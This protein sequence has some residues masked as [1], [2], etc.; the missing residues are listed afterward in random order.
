MDNGTRKKTRKS[1]AGNL[2]RP[3]LSGLMLPDEWTTPVARRS[4]KR[5]VRANELLR[6]IRDYGPLSRAEAARMLGFNTRTVSLCLESLQRDGLIVKQKE[7]TRN[8]RGRRPVPWAFNPHAACVLG[9]DVGRSVITSTVMDLAG[10]VLVSK[11]FP[12]DYPKAP[13]QQVRWLNG[14]ASRML[15]EPAVKALPLAGIGLCP[16]GIFHARNAGTR[17]REE[18]DWLGASLCSLT[19]APVFVEDDSRLV[20]LGERWFGNISDRVP[21]I[22]T[23]NVTDGLGVAVI[24]GDSLYTGL[25]HAAGELGHVPLGE[26]GVPCYCGAQSCLENTASGHGIERMAAQARLARNGK[27]C[28]AVDVMEMAPANETARGIVARFAEGL[29]L[30]TTVVLSLLNPGVLV[31]SGRLARF[32][33]LY[34]ET[35]RRELARVAPPFIVS[36]TP[37]IVSELH[38]NAVTYGTC[39]R[40]LHQIFGTAQVSLRQAL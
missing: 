21:S 1:A 14:I 34:M 19:G 32:A 5:H 25:T 13:E 18:A 33:P 15:S 3:V 6:V 30:G 40:V 36:A 24:I 2:P 35:F 7:R 10:N 12:L 4:A 29:A 8:V 26:R 17:F 20:A 11:P 31:I 38:E 16:E 27:P 37:I 39:A 23:L 22:A 9:I 28:S